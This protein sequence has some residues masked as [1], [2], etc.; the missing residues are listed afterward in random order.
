MIL[1]ILVTGDFSDLSD[2]GD[3]SDPSDLSDRGDL[4]V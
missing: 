2:P 3:L 1:V 4:V